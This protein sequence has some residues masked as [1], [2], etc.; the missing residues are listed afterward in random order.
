[1]DVVKKVSGRQRRRRSGGGQHAV[2]GGE[3]GECTSGRARAVKIYPDVEGGGKPS[4]TV[5][6]R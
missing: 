5:H 3:E 4:G 1:M 6:A 2:M